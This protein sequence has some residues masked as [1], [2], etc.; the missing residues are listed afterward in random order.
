MEIFL[1]KMILDHPKM[2][3]HLKENSYYFKYLNRDARFYKDFTEKMKE[4]YHER[5]TDKI[6]DAIDNMDLISNVLMAFK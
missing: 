1:Q 3:Q 5:T 4:L 6:S 2:Y